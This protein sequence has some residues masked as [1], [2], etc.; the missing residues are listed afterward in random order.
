VRIYRVDEH[1]KMHTCPA[2]PDPHPVDIRRTIVHVTDPQPCLTPT[3]DSIGAPVE[4]SRYEIRDRQCDH[5]RTVITIGTI[6][7]EHLD[8]PRTASLIPGLSGLASD[9]CTVCGDPLAA[10]LADHGRHIGCHP[11]RTAA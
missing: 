7:V 10:V 1:H 9:P 11:Y 6:T 4:C 5:C 8:N 3:Y 2:D